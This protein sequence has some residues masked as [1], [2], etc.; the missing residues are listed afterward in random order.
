MKIY[1]FQLK[2]EVCILS[3]SDVDL[4]ENDNLRIIPSISEGK[5]VFEFEEEFEDGISDQEYNELA[6][7]ISHNHGNDFISPVIIPNTFSGNYNNKSIKKMIEGFRSL[8]SAN[9]KDLDLGVR[10]MTG[11]VITI[12]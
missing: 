12:K 5:I 9:V 3:I 1:I 8:G 6:D 2:K 11:V 10:G 4:I 7:R